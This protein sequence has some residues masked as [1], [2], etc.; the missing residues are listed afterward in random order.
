MTPRY[1]SAMPTKGAG[2]KSAIKTRI[3]KC[4]VGIINNKFL[5]RMYLRESLRHCSI[6][7]MLC[8]CLTAAI[9]NLST[10]YAASSLQE[11]HLSVRRAAPY[12][13]RNSRNHY[14]LIRDDLAL[15]AMSCFMSATGPAHSSWKHLR[16]SQRSRNPIQNLLQELLHPRSHQR[17]RQ[18]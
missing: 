13:I 17:L 10:V 4:V 9:R 1:S 16:R 5:S 15:Q 6:R 18:R 2:A 14:L 7:H 11:V 3:I 8:L 12:G